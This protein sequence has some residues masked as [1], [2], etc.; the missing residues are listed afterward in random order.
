MWTDEARPSG[1]APASREL[2][3]LPRAIRRVLGVAR[4]HARRRT[5]EADE[6]F[7]AER[8]ATSRRRF[9]GASKRPSG[10]RGSS[11]SLS[12]PQ[13]LTSRTSHASRWIAAAAAAGLI[14][15]VGVGQLMD[16]RHHSV[17]RRPTRADA[18]VATMPRG[19]D[20]RMQYRQ[21]DARRS[22]P[23][24]ARR[25]ALARR[26]FPSC[27]R[28]T[29]LRRAPANG[30]GKRVGSPQPL[31][32]RKGLDM[33]E[34]VAGELA[35][36]YDS[37]IVDR[38]RA[39][40]LPPPVRP[41]DRPPRARIRVLLRRRSR[42]RLRVSGPPPLSRPQRLP[43][44]RNHPQPARQRSASREGHPVPLGSRRDATERSAR[45]TS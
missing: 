35:A 18:R 22:I 27:A 40:R 41:A 33:K 30:P 31:I 15:G 25:L 38:V 14:V 4:E 23:L 45:T 24:R 42:R 34:A 16:L 3:R 17:S 5:T 43:D 36:A 44:R 26:R 9:S 1:R 37:A 39:Q 6:N 12:S 10:P 13:P 11:H 19:R 8:L 21:R 29:R 7:P 32:F 2:P 20:P 28:S